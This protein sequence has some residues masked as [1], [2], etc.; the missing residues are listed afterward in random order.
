MG[1]GAGRRVEV[2]LL[3]TGDVHD[4]IEEQELARSE[5]TNHHATSAEA[6]SAELHETNLGS[7][8]A[9]A[10]GNGALATS[11][12]LV[13]L[14]EQGVSR[15]RDDGSAHT[16]NHTRQ[17]GSTQLGATGQLGLGLAH[18]GGDA[19]SSLALHGELGHGVGNLLH[20]NGA[21]TRVKTLD[22]TLLGKKLASAGD[23]AVGEGRLGHEAD[24]GGLE[25]AQEDIGDELSHGGRGQV[26]GGLVVPGLLVTK[27]LGELHLEELDTT[28][29]E[30]T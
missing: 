3:S 16:S 26:D 1:G 17:Q 11:A 12:G 15:V 6:D 27:V 14:G 21:E 4:D 19:V 29:L 9:Q 24:T 20:E 23:E 13:H 28:E 8:A 18:S 10:G 25:G 7:N 30:P 2:E 22:Q 5:G